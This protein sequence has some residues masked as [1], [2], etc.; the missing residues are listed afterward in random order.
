MFYL[1]AHKNLY[2][3]SNQK[4]IAALK[5]HLTAYEKIKDNICILL[6]QDADIILEATNGLEDYAYEYCDSKHLPS[7]LFDL[8]TDLEAKS[9]VLEDLNIHPKVVIDFYER[10]LQEKSR[11]HFIRLQDQNRIYGLNFL[12]KKGQERFLLINNAVNLSVSHFSWQSLRIE[13]SA[14]SYF[15]SMPT[16]LDLQ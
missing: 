15:S 3:K 2:M 12:T 16:W 8:F 1:I 6:E 5:I 10:A 11:S 13:D 4:I 7:Q 9:I 14:S